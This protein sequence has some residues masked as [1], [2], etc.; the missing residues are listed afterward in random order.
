MLIPRKIKQF[1][2]N[3][4]PHRIIIDVREPGEFEGGAIPGAINLPIGS[5]PEALMLPEEE[6]QDRFGIPKPDKKENEV[7]FYCKAGI[8]SHSAAELAKQAGY[9]KVAEYPGSWM[10]WIKKKQEEGN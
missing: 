3:P 6:F 2:A 10:D 8:R 7:V 4:S 1:T 5:S 9:E